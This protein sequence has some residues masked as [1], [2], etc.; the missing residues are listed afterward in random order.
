MAWVFFTVSLGV[1]LW[2]TNHLTPDREVSIPLAEIAVLCNN[3]GSLV[4]VLDGP[5]M[6][7]KFGFS[8]VCRKT[9][10]PGLA[11]RIAIRGAVATRTRPRL[12][13]ESGDAAF[14]VLPLAGHAWYG[15]IPCGNR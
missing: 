5:P 11:G 3:N 10:P 4:V 12:V 15:T 9:V 8:A 1:R 7:G 2:L 6:V 13:G 14:P